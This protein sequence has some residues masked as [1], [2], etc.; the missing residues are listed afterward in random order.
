MKNKFKICCFSAV[1][2]T[3]TLYGSYFIKS[4]FVFNTTK[5]LPQYVF[6]IEGFARNYK[7]QHGDYVSVCPFYSKMKDFYKI[8][9][10]WDHGSCDNGVVPLIKKVAAIPGDVITVNDQNDMTVNEKNIKNTRALSSKIKHFNYQGIVPP[11]HYLLYTPHPEGFDS[12][13]LGLIT[14][15]EIIF[16]LNPVL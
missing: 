11:K 1:L 15:N 13:Y 12:R 4:N 16:K 2:V 3:V 9:E 7:L 5:S 14:D 10:H 8:K 6:Y